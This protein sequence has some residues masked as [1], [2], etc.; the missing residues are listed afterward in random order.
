MHVQRS[1][2]KEIRDQPERGGPRPLATDSTRVFGRRSEAVTY[3]TGQ[4]TACTLL[5]QS[6]IKGLTR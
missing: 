6:P 4:I 2:I 5:Q 1:T 3:I